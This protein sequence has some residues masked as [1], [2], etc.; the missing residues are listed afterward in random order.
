MR[1]VR[2][3]RVSGAG[4][5]CRGRNTTR[6]RCIDA[7][8][9]MSGVELLVLGLLGSEGVFGLFCLLGVLGVYQAGIARL[10]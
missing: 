2:F 7:T 4:Q 1:G 9:H 8:V 6:E 10:F 3:T 5:V